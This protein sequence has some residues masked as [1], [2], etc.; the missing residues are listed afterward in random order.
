MR[1]TFAFCS[2]SLAV[3]RC[4]CIT[5]HRASLLYE[6]QH[7]SLSDLVTGPVARR[8]NKAGSAFLASPIGRNQFYGLPRKIALCLEKDPEG[9]TGHSMRRSAA[10]AAAN[11]GAS[12]M[13]LRRHFGWRGESTP[14]LYLDASTTH[15]RNVAH[16]MSSQPAQGTT[17]GAPSQS[18]VTVDLNVNLPR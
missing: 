1:C 14:Q 2:A 17:T 15:Q 16:M 18:R 3:Q 9:Y 8:I 13:D 7:L 11:G 5:P 12:T 4:S 10:L 6:T